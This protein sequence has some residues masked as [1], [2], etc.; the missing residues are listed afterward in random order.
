MTML[1]FKLINRSNYR[2]A[3]MCQKNQAVPRTVITSI[4]TVSI[5]YK[6]W[7]KCV[8]SFAAIL[9]K[10]K[11]IFTLIVEIKLVFR[12]KHRTYHIMRY[13]RGIEGSHNPWLVKILVQ[14]SALVPET[15]RKPEKSITVQKVNSKK[16]LRHI[17]YIE[18]IG[19]R[20]ALETWRQGSKQVQRRTGNLLYIS[21]RGKNPKCWALPQQSEEFSDINT[22]F[23]NYSSLKR[24]LLI[25][26]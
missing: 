20:I 24:R 3:R 18:N 11:H 17:R 15:H 4:W 21:W 9:Y 10:I 12:S 8:R 13:A 7:G 2:D 23:L 26:T 6:T 1:I 5:Q 22:K 16:Y 25:T 19:D 14:K